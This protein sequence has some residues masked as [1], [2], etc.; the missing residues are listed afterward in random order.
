MTK[1]FSQDLSKRSYDFE[2]RV[3]RRV[4]AFVVIAASFVTQGLSAESQPPRALE[5]Q[6]LTLDTAENRP[7]FVPEGLLSSATSEEQPLPRNS[8]LY[9]QRTGSF[10]RTRAAARSVGRE[11]PECDPAGT[12]S[13]G[14]A[15]NAR[16][17]TELLPDYQYGVSGSV[18]AIIPGWSEWRSRVVR[19]VYVEINDIHFDRTG[20]LKKG[21]R[22]AFDLAGG[23]IQVEGYRVCSE[24]PTGL[25]APAVGDP[26]VVIASPFVGDP[27]YALGSLVFTVA[28]EVAKP[29]PIAGLSSPA[30][31]TLLDLKVEL[32]GQQQEARQP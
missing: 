5:S 23:V 27:R 18:V 3:A 2:G 17:L 13:L 7:M 1:N 9:S 6:V 19:M 15:W 32:E 29:F 26:L 31:L 11:I 4:A 16:K 28:G 30:E 8:V 24:V 14:S 22:I 21:D 20:S 12:V 25:P 10:E